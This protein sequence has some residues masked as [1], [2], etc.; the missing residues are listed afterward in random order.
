MSRNHI[1]SQ[2]T[3]ER[4]PSSDGYMGSPHTERS[5]KGESFREDDPTTSG[6]NLQDLYQTKID[7]VAAASGIGS[8]T[9]A[10]FP[11]STMSSSLSPSST[12]SQEKHSL[13]FSRFFSSKG[14]NDH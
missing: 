2:Q 7:S 5:Q 6:I 3:I 14:K 12:P 9:G 10:E 1:P 13:G 11:R 4:F 8:R